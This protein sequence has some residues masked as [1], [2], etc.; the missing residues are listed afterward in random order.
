MLCNFISTKSQC[1]GKSALTLDSSA[2]GNLLL[3]FGAC[4]ASQAQPCHVAL[5]SNDF[6]ARRRAT[7]V[8]HEH[9]ILG[10]RVWVSER[11][12]WKTIVNHTE[13]RNLCL[14]SVCGLDTEQTTK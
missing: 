13:L 5:D 10:Y 14:L 6:C 3:Y 2:Q 7:D 8:D 11:L 9:F 12:S 4:R 1:K